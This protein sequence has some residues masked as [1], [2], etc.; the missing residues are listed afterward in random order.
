MDSRHAALLKALGEVEIEDEELDVSTGSPSFSLEAV[1][2]RRSVASEAQQTAMHADWHDDVD[3]RHAALLEA[4]GEVEIEDEELDV[5]TGSPSFSLEAVSPR[6]SVASEAQQAAM[7]AG[8]HDDVDSRHAALLKALGEVEIEDEELD[9][10]TGSPSF[11]L[12]AVSPRR[13]VASEAQ[14]TAMH[15]DWHGD[16]DS[17]HAALLKALGEVEIEDE[18][19]DVS[20]DSPSFALEAVSPRRSAA[21]QSQ[22]TAMHADWHGDVDSRHAALLKA[23]G[24]VEIED[25]E[26]DVSTGS[27]SFSLEAVSQQRSVASEAQQT[28]IHADWHGDVDSR[29][30][31]L[32]KALGEVEIE[33]EELDVST[34]SPSFALEAVSPRRSV[35]SEAQQAA[36]H[37]DWHGDVDSRHAALL[38]ALGEVEIEDEEL[39]VSTGSPSFS[40]EAVS[41]R[42]SVAS[43]AQQAAMH[44]DWH[45]DVDSRHAALLKA[46]GEVEIEDEELDVSTGSP[47]FSLEAVSPRRSVASEAEQTA[48]HADWHGD[49]D[50]RHAALLKALGEVEIEDEELDVSTGS[51]SFSLEAVSPRGSAANQ[52][53]QTA[54][55]ADWHDVDSRHAALLK[56]LGEVEIEDEELDVSTGS[57]SFSLEAVSPRRSVASEAQQTAMHAD[58]HGDVDSRHAALLKALGEVEI[59]DEELDVSTG[60]PSFSLEAVS[61]RGSAANQS[62]QTAMHADWHGDVDSRH[63]ALLKALGE[64][65]IEDEELDVST[66]SPSFSLEAVSPR[67]SV[68]SEAQQT[69]MHADWHGDVDSR[70]TA[71]LKALGEGEHE[72]D[73]IHAHSVF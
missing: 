12:E 23:L 50:S 7:H 73:E 67:R 29:H 47:S 37:A 35:A 55:H 21:S 40:L 20:T 19:L 45:D 41:P 16:V 39:D 27:P 42:R 71:L 54:M 44:A 10:S 53:Q 9:V 65:E 17:R 62:Q 36:M 66:G 58:W 57:P 5:S 25:E 64:V 1:S 6:R 52:S 43:E 4:L 24:E 33:D 22:Q 18:K 56:A 2:P 63:A 48:M 59:E 61:P 8:W 49:V 14:Q 72:E 3:S 38:K 51:P 28:A 46:L 69:A 60:S 34:G 32:L 31:A 11:S 30:T 70:H 26:L 15:A 13:S 68:A